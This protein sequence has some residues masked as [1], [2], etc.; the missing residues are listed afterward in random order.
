[1][2]ERPALQQAS[3]YC[4]GVI[5][6][7]INRADNINKNPERVRRLMRSLARAQGSQ[8]PISVI[9]GDISANEGSPIDSDSVARY[10]EALK[11]ALPL[12]HEQFPLT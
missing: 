5:R 1:M 7:D 6:S 10:I 12:C 8:T 2:R 11:N 9:A 3:D 4:D